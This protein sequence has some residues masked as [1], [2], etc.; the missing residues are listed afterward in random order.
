M[1]DYYFSNQME[2][3]NEYVEIINSINKE[4]ENKLIYL[5][6]PFFNIVYDG[7]YI[8]SL[9][10]LIA[11]MLSNDE[12]ILNQIVENE[13]L[14]NDLIFIFLEVIQKESSRNKYKII[15]ETLSNDISVNEINNI[16]LWDAKLIRNKIAHFDFKIN[17]NILQIN[18]KNYY[19]KDIIDIIYE[20]IEIFMVIRRIVEITGILR[21]TKEMFDELR[22]DF[23]NKG[24]D[25]NTF[26]ENDL[27]EY[28]KSLNEK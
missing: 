11:Y 15:K 7:A 8:R 6:L 25:L 5:Y 10:M 13:K 2:F 9:N 20:M 3:V 27:I 24:Y 28:I 1:S 26:S 12:T 23:I 17:N 4:K 19:L 22:K 16:I 14:K 21:I 18:N